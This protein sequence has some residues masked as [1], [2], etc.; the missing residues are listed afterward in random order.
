MY[1]AWVTNG[2]DNSNIVSKGELRPYWIFSNADYPEW[3]MAVDAIT[4]SVFTR[5]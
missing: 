5:N 3:S 2:T 4:G 1:L